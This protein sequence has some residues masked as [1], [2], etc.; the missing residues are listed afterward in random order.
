MVIAINNDNEK[1][2]K[3]KQLFKFEAGHRLVN[4]KG[5]CHNVHGHNYK[6]IVEL[7]GIPDPETKILIDTYDLKEIIRENIIERCDHKMLNEVFC[8]NNPT[9]EYM[10]KEF[11]W[12]LNDKFKNSISL[13]HVRVESIEVFENDECSA[14]YEN[15]E[16]Y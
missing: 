1:F 10:A 8:E 6:V 9:M 4:H 11:F 3:I 5:K 15:P 16:K 12:N 2:I 7:K 14:I 13:D